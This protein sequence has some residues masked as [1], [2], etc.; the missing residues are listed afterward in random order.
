VIVI[1]IDEAGRTI[2]RLA[3]LAGGDSA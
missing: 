3:S 1:V 2:A